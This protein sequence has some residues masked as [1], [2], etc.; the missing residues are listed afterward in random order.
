MVISTLIF[1]ALVVAITEIL[2]GLR[3]LDR[4][5]VLYSWAGIAVINSLLLYRFPYD[6]ARWYRYGQQKMG[7]M[8]QRLKLWQKIALGGTCIVGLLAF[9]QGL[10]YPPN[11]WDSMTYHMARITSWI[12]H[13]SVYDYPTHILRQNYQPPFA[14]YLIMHTGLLCGSDVFANT[15][16]FFFLL[17]TLVSLSLIASYW[18]LKAHYKILLL[19]IAF[20]IPEV[21]L[22]SSSTQNDI[23]ISF[24][25]VTA[26]YFILR[27][28]DRP[29][30][31]NYLWLG[32]TTGLALL[33]KGTAYLYFAPMLLFWG[34]MAMWEWYRTK[35]FAY[36][37]NFVIAILV[38]VL[39]NV[40]FYYRNYQLNHNVLGIGKKESAQYAN[41][42]MNASLLLSS[43]VKNAGLH[44]GLKHIPAITYW[45]NDVIHKFHDLTGIPIDGRDVNFA[46]TKFSTNDSPSDE[47]LAPN[48]L[49]FLLITVAFGAFIILMIKGRT[50]GNSR[51]LFLILVV[52][53]ILFCAYL[54]WQPYSTRLHTP[55][56]LLS[57][58]L[59]GYILS[60]SKTILRI[61]HVM[62]PLMVIYAFIMV[63]SNKQRPLDR[64]L[65]DPRYA[66]FFTMRYQI[67]QDHT[68]I[69]SVISRDH[70][71]RIGLLVNSDAWTYPL[72]YDAFSRDIEPIYIG[73]HNFTRNSNPGSSDHLD[74]IITTDVNAP[75]ID[76]NGKRYYNRTAGNANL[77]LYR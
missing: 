55:I 22:Q 15:I 35:R 24:F 67:E 63:T 41:Q 7:M 38:A 56:F 39:I 14:E 74:C 28:L 16:Q 54:K 50:N 18:G 5:H 13:R 33:T 19:I 2:S 26:F 37:I 51:F 66:K 1:G 60:V 17:I 20:T 71:K 64:H 73:V 3:V 69:K 34:L 42:K 9:I 11:N 30:T 21:V 48:L 72:F 61:S 23:V 25:V 46:N 31:T 70:F 27:A 57:V 62:L 36:A 12:S 29:T 47:D 49:H 44:I 65:R 76:H 40:A 4:T 53:V 43:A 77:F 6:R 10:V 45:A 75:Y 8:L 52:Q 32:L 58:V 59:L 68:P